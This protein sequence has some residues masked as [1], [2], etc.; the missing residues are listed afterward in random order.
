MVRKDGYHFRTVQQ[1][2]SNARSQAGDFARYASCTAPNS[3][4]VSPSTD[5]EW[6]FIPQETSLL[7]ERNARRNILTLRH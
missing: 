1:H 7:A 6:S 2:E 3:P 5:R 4:V